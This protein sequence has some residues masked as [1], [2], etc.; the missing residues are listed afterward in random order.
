LRQLLSPVLAPPLWK[1]E[2]DVHLLCF[3]CSGPLLLLTVFF[4]R[5]P[6]LPCIERITRS[7]GELLD[8]HIHRPDQDTWKIPAPPAP[9]NTPFGSGQASRCCRQ[10]CGHNGECRCTQEGGAEP[11]SQLDQRSHPEQQQ[12]QYF[13]R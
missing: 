5:I 2:R 9:G 3:S 8:G 7:D 13:S 11:R 6:C 1:M 12:L 10:T 4:E